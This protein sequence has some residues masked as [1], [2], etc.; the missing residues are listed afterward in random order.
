MRLSA[1]ERAEIETLARNL[2]A[3][4]QS[5]Q[6]SFAEKHQI[7]RRLL[8]RAVVWCRPRLKK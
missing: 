4:W 1:A 3:L 8:E 6:T 2:P 5:S 7:V